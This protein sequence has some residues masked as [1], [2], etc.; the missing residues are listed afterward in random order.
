M[1]RVVFDS[2]TVR[3]ARE[4]QH[5]VKA[6][7]QPSSGSSRPRGPTRRWRD[8]SE[9]ETPW[10]LL[11]RPDPG[12]PTHYGEAVWEIEDLQGTSRPWNSS[13]WRRERLQGYL[14]IFTINNVVRELVGKLNLRGVEAFLKF[15]NV[16]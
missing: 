11:R 8:T 4:G 9:W 5:D 14:T 15:S 12:R 6:Q 2:R 10:S 7:V 1:A 3:E 16:I 13:S